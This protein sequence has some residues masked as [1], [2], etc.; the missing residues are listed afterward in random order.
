MKKTKFKVGDRVKFQKQ[1]YDVVDIRDHRIIIQGNNKQWNIDF[2]D[3]QLLELCLTD[4]IIT[5]IKDK[6]Q[7]QRVQQQLINMGY[8]WALEDVD[9]VRDLNGED[10]LG[11]DHIIIDNEG[12]LDR[13][14]DTE[15]AIDNYLDYDII[16]A[17]E[18]LNELPEIEYSDGT[19]MKKNHWVVIQ[20]DVILC[21]FESK[22]D[23]LKFITE[24]WDVE[25][26]RLLEVVDEF[27]VGQPE[28]KPP[29]M[30]R[31]NKKSLLEENEDEDYYY[32]LLT[33]L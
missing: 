26:Y 9:V 20:D 22:E 18:F 27:C 3:Y 19:T 21:R 32:N 10:G 24:D 12:D 17:N 6:A 2:D 4:T 25:E 33:D 8:K 29:I 23:A 1:F 5:N 11:I 7:H 15:S 30:K 16:K 28:P 14:E 13:H 31:I